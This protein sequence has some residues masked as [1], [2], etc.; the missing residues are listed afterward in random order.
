MKKIKIRRRKNTKRDKTNKPDKT[1]TLQAVAVASDSEVGS[2]HRL[3]Q[4]LPIP[5]EYPTFLRV[6]PY[7][8]FSFESDYNN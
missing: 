2:R 5:T 4:D 6:K 1:A 7:F 8:C 3:F